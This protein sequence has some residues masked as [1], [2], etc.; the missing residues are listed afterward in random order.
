MRSFGWQPRVSLEQGLA[1]AY[2][3]FLAGTAVAAH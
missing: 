1:L 2:A 3:D